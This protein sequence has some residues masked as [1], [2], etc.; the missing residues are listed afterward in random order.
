MRNTPLTAPVL[1]CL[2]CLSTDT[3]DVRVGSCC[4]RAARLIPLQLGHQLGITPQSLRGQRPLQQSSRVTDKL[5]LSSSKG[6]LNRSFR[7]TRRHPV[8]YAYSSTWSVRADS[9]ILVLSLFFTFTFRIN[10][11]EV[12][13]YPLSGLL[14]DKPWSQ[15]SSLLPPVTCLH[16]LSRI[17]FSIPTARRFSSN[18]AINTITHAFELSAY[19]FLSK[20]HNPSYL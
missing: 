20:K 13:F 9:P 8:L 1:R 14:L 2:T 7:S 3:F 16:F 5:R 19:Q 12:L 17:G 6:G 10:S 4:T 15:V 11:S 18:V